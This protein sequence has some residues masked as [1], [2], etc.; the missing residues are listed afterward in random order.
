[1]VLMCRILCALTVKQK[2]PFWASVSRILARSFA[3]ARRFFL[4]I[5]AEETPDFFDKF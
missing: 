5:L 3:N 1:M 2:P 4:P